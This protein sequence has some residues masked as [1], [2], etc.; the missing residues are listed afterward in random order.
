VK[1]SLPVK[2]LAEFFAYAK[3]V[4]GKLNFATAGVNNITHLGSV[5][6]FKRAGVD[7][8]MVAT[9]G[10]PQAVTDL[11]SGNVDFYASSLLRVGEL[12]GSL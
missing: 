3:T 7:L 6:L 9:R 12:T 8:V 4:P 10:E 11:I 2:T 1:S 5:L